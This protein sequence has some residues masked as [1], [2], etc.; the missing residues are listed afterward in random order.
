MYGHTDEIAKRLRT[1]VYG[2]MKT[3][4]A[5]SIKDALPP[6]AGPSP[7]P[8]QPLLFDL[9]AENNNV[10]P[11]LQVFNTLFLRE[12]NRYVTELFSRDRTMSDEEMYQR[13]RARNRA[14]FQKITYEEYLPRLLGSGLPAYKGFNASARGGVTSEFCTVAMRYGH[15]AQPGI[16]PR[17]LPGRAEV[18]EGHLVLRDHFLNTAAIR[19]HNIDSLLYGAATVSKELLVSARAV[20][21]MRNFF[22]GLS[23][24]SGALRYYDIPA[25]DVQRGR[26]HGLPTF[27][28]ARAALGLPRFTSWSQFA[29]ENQAP[30]ATLYASIDDVDLLAGAASEVMGYRGSQVGETTH[31]ILVRQFTALRDA[32]RYWYENPQSSAAGKWDK[33][34]TLTTLVLTNTNLKVFPA[35]P[36]VQ[37][38]RLV[39][40]SAALDALAKNGELLAGPS[41]AADSLQAGTDGTMSARLADWF[42]LSWKVSGDSVT[43][44]ATAT[45]RGWVGLGFQSDGRTGMAGAD[46]VL[47]TWDAAS[48]KGSVE[49]YHAAGTMQPARD[50]VQSISSAS[51]TYDP[52]GDGT[53]VLTFTRPL[54]SSD[55]DDV[56]LSLSGTS[57]VIFATGAT[58]MDLASKH[59][60]GSRGSGT[61]NLASGASKTKTGSW[62][63]FVWIHVVGMILSWVVMA[64]IAVISI[65]YFKTSG[66]SATVVHKV[67]MGF[68]A[69]SLAPLVLL[70]VISGLFSRGGGGG[71]SRLQVFHLSW[72]WIYVLLIVPQFILGHVID[73]ARTKAN[74]AVRFRRLRMSHRNAGRL[75]LILVIPQIISGYVLSDMG[76][77]GW[78][79]LGLVIGVVALAVLALE[80]RK[81]GHVGDLSSLIPKV[82][83]G[84]GGNKVQ[85]IT[86]RDGKDTVRRS[87][88]VMGISERHLP[89]VRQVSGSASD[90]APAR[91]MSREALAAAVSAGQM[92]L[93]FQGYVLDLTEWVDAHPGGSEVI[94]NHLGRDV[95]DLLLKGGAATGGHVHS[96]LALRK[97]EKMRIASFVD[98]STRETVTD[99]RS[100]AG[101]VATFAPILAEA[102]G[103]AGDKTSQRERNAWARA[104]STWDGPVMSVEEYHVAVLRDGELFVTMDGFVLDL[105]GYIAEH[106]GG[107]QLLQ[108]WIGRDITLA[109]VDM[110]KLASVAKSNNSS[111]QGMFSHSGAAFSRAI[112]L[113]FARLNV[114]DAEATSIVVR[115]AGLQTL[116]K[117]VELQASSEGIVRPDPAAPETPEPV[118]QLVDHLQI[119]LVA[120]RLDKRE[121]GNPVALLEF[122]CSGKNDIRPTP[123]PGQHY[124]FAGYINGRNMRRQYTPVEIDTVSG[125]VVLLVSLIPNGAFSGLLA[126]MPIGSSIDASLARPMGPGILGLASK[127]TSPVSAFI[128]LAGGV[129]LS[130]FLWFLKHLSTVGSRPA[131]CATTVYLLLFERHKG[132]NLLPKLCEE[133][134]NAV[135]LNRACGVRCIYHRVRTKAPPGVAGLQG[136]ISKELL[137]AATGSQNLASMMAFVSGSPVFERSCDDALS[138]CGVQHIHIM[139]Q[140]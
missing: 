62:P 58:S 43:F 136:H 76:A 113:R 68:V 28:D 13:A 1:G 91:A 21:D 32:D 49:D 122:E 139:T 22:V 48:G 95:T 84:R 115:A 80:L 103:G 111:P 79:F 50:S 97:T 90:S 129:G 36:F 140:G 40:D 37:G 124:W 88:S 29:A 125:K 56:S 127:A 130:S 87:T 93:V 69:S 44:V 55:A 134:S 34:D 47:G 108:R 19:A 123:M 71:R 112:G 64:P 60:Y 133:V 85:Y 81:R 2:L 18:E 128:L 5:P 119:T 99:R 86:D 131:H 118:A 109:F 11:M 57:S 30:L 59:P 53:A 46:I 98:K 66:S 89:A 70:T 77:G 31:H 38:S 63:A 8:G 7:V 54:R 4:V 3:S 35:N 9:G 100:S 138:T 25:A 51:F 27:N 106:P 101:G 132:S 121:E 26:D 33:S 105:G 45:T 107:G 23:G 135:N 78:I 137:Q 16:I 92:Y 42:Q 12:H 65:R 120:R 94:K 75:M 72:A 114:P 14:L 102:E 24:E 61:L 41:A 82:L 15:S 104:S 6:N 110:A 20:L 74:Y 52:S 116:V 17:S 96:R 126:S 39:G 117:A 83:T 10:Q 73:L 67:I